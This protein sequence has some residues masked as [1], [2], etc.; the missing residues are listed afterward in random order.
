MCAAKHAEK[1]KVRVKVRGQRSASL[2]HMFILCIWTVE[3]TL[4]KQIR[5]EM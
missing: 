4:R 3:M 2:L 5:Q 1:N